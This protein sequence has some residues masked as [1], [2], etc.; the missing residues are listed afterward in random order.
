MQLGE[1]DR[2]RSLGTKTLGHTYMMWDCT[3]KYRCTDK[4][5]EMP[6]KHSY[7]FFFGIVKNMD[8]MSGGALP[9]SQVLRDFWLTAVFKHSR[10][11]EDVI[12][13]KL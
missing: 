5:L 9:A 6:S 7:F 3:L 2:V 4:D 10:M 13:I 1:R 12:E 11:L 8:E